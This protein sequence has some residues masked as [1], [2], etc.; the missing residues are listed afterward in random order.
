MGEGCNV[1]IRNI[2]YY[3]RGNPW[4]VCVGVVYCVCYCA[5][6]VWPS[7]KPPLC[8]KCVIVYLHLI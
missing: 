7:E 3:I 1:L 5:G 2:I 8:V 4:Y 6:M